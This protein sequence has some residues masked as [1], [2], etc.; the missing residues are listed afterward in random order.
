[1]CNS[2]SPPFEAHVS[3]ASVMNKFSSGESK[4]TNF[5]VLSVVQQCEIN[6]FWVYC[7]VLKPQN[8]EVVGGNNCDK[9]LKN[10]ILP[11]V[12]IH[13][14]PKDML[15][16]SATGP[17]TFKILDLLVVIESYH[18]VLQTTALNVWKSPSY[19]YDSTS[20][21]FAAPRGREIYGKSFISFCL[22][23]LSVLSTI[24]TITDWLPR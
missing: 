3:S 21:I 9:T 13:L 12:H 4:F 2:R 23:Y 20:H 6:R 16:I 14:T 15:Y 10:P 5:V 22:G 17:K 18:H 8:S 19:R 1:M 7:L 24:T 11:R